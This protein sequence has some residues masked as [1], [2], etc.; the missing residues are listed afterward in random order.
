LDNSFQAIWLKQGGDSQMG[1]G[2][3]KLDGGRN[4]VV[5]MWRD[6][7]SSF[8]LY[9][10]SRGRDCGCVW[11]LWREVGPTLKEGWLEKT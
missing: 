5:L 8:K 11:V 6:D 3:R 9:D 7:D 1:G 4:M 2:F 10:S